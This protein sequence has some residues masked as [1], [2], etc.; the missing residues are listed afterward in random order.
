MALTDDMLLM[1][2]IT[3]INHISA[4][5]ERLENSCLQPILP[6]LEVAAEWDIQ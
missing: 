2:E 4:W 1:F 6:H 3:W 5:D